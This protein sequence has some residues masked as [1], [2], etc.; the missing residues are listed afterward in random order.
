M[1]LA[2]VK[3]SQ[4]LLICASVLLSLNALSCSDRSLQGKSFKLEISNNQIDLAERLPGQ[5]DRVCVLGPYTDNAR[6]TNVLGF[7][8]EVEAATKITD[9]DD[10]ALLVTSQGQTAVNLWEIART[11]VDFSVMAG[12]CY[13]RANTKFR[14]SP[15]GLVSATN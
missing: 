14:I 6:A 15:N 9:F 10:I 11:N 7:T 8:V 5:W 1:V 13:D 3:L 12:E 4:D 2:M